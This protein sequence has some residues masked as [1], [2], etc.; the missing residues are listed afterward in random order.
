MNFS[1]SCRDSF[2]FDDSICPEGPPIRTH[3]TLGRVVALVIA[4]AV[5]TRLAAQEPIFT[6]VFPSQTVDLGQNVTLSVA[7]DWIFANP[8]ATYTAIWIVAPYGGLAKTV[9]EID[10]VSAANGLVFSYAIP[11]FDANDEGEYVFYLKDGA[12]SPSCA[13][14]VVLKKPVG[15][16]L[17]PSGAFDTAQNA[18]L[19]A[20]NAQG[21]EISSVSDA[22]P[23]YTFP[24]AGGLAGLVDAALQ[25]S[26]LQNYS[27]S[28]GGVGDVPGATGSAILAASPKDFTGNFYVFGYGETTNSYIGSSG[29]GQ[30]VK[31]NGISTWSGHPSPAHRTADRFDVWSNYGE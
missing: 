4:L 17:T 1:A 13:A 23:L 2:I 21:F 14:E 18:T 29:Y 16:P 25:N 11:S 28:F 31:A 12:G 6:D 9:K 10:G 20:L 19:T 5:G 26:V 24:S 3:A 7:V 30:F 8:A 22:T 27:A 15:S